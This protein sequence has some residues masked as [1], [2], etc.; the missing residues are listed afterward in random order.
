M[1]V[2]PAQVLKNNNLVD[3]SVAVSVVVSVVISVVVLIAVSFQLFQ[4]CP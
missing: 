4:L 1:A 3:V 2:Y